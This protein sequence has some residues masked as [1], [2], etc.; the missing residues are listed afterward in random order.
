[1]RLR[2]AALHLAAATAILAPLAGCTAAHLGPKFGES[3]R[4]TMAAQTEGHNAE[5]P[6]PF[7]AEDA[8]HAVKRHRGNSGDAP[9]GASDDA[10][11]SLSLS[12]SSSSSGGGG[13]IRLEAK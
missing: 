10:A 8:R 13:P 12:S 3:Y 11:G 4:A 2:L 7:D 5:E 9:S 1:M 6:A